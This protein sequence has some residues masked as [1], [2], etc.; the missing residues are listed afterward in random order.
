MDYN[1]HVLLPYAR[2]PHQDQRFF[3]GPALPFLT[4]LAFGPLLYGAFQPGYYPP[5]PPYRPRP[6]YYPYGYPY[7]YPKW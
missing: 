3:P 1:R 4:G 2:S 6:P 7:G 5:Y